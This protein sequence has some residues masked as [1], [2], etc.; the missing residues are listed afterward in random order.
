MNW[1]ILSGVIVS[2]FFIL[3]QLFPAILMNLRHK[4]YEKD[5]INS[6]QKLIN[7]NIKKEKNEN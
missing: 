5:F 4:Y 2:I 7:E 3:H 1:L 6:Q